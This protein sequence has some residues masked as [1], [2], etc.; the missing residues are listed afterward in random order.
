MR[1]AYKISVGKPE[2]DAFGDLGV[3]RII[4]KWVSKKDMREWTRFM[5]PR[6]GVSCRLL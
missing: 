6:T 5:W 3:G 4:L 1:N 2:T